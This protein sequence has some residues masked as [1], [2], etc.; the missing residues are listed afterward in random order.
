MNCILIS[1]LIKSTDLSNFVTTAASLPVAELPAHLRSFPI[2]WPFPRGDLYHWIPLLDRFDAILERFNLVYGLNSGPQTR[3]FSRVLL[4]QGIGASDHTSETRLDKIEE[5][6]FGQE[7]DREL[8]ETILAFSTLLVENCGNRS[9][10]NSSDRLGDLLNTTSLS[11]LSKSLRLAVRLAQRYHTSRQR[12]GNASQH[13]NNALLASHYNIDIEHVQKLANS[14]VKSPPPSSSL[15]ASTPSTASV[16]KGR[17]KGSLENAGRRKSPGPIHAS[18]LYAMVKDEESFSS[19]P[20][21]KGGKG[22]KQGLTDWRDWGS[23][24]YNYYQ[25]SSEEEKRPTISGIDVVPSAPSTPTP[26]RRTSGLLRPSRLSSS[27]ESSNVPNTNAITKQEEPNME[28]GMR[29]VEIPY[30]RIAS[31]ALEE[32]LKSVIPEIPK[33]SRYGLLCR[34]RIA[35]AMTHSLSTRRQILAIRILAITNLAYIYPETTF[36]LKILQQDSDEPRRLQL[37]YQL[38]DLIHPPG[39]GQAGIPIELKTIALGALEALTKH[40]SRASDVCAALNVNVNHGVLL[41]VLRKT[42]ADLAIE[43]LDGES[44]EADEWREALFSLLEALPLSGQRTAESLVAAGLFDTIIEM[45]T[46]HTNKAERSHPKVLIFLN[47]IIYTIRDAFQTFANCKGLDTISDLAAW[48]VSSSLERAEAGNGLSEHYRNQVMDYQIPYFQQQTLRWIFKFVNHMMSHGNTNFDRLLR[49]LVDSPQLL[50]GLRIVIANGPVF[51][52][53]VWSG[54]VNI[55]S[56]FIHNEPTSYAVI[57]EAGLSKGF[58]EAITLTTIPDIVSKSS[59]SEADPSLATDGIVGTSTVVIRESSDNQVSTKRAVSLSRSDDK[60]LAQGILPATDAIVTI[61]HAFGA[62][63]LNTAGLD[64]F[65]KSGALES[66]FEV[67]ESS[68]HVKSLT[69]EIDL[70]RMLGNSFDELVRH[71][72]RLKSAVMEAVIRMLARVS[73]L[74]RTKAS[75]KGVGAQLLAEDEDGDLPR[76]GSSMAQVDTSNENDGDVVMS[77]TATGSGNPD[78]E[79]ARDTSHKEFVQKLDERNEPVVSTY[80]NVAVRFLAGFFENTGLCASFIEAGGVGYILDIATLPSLPYDFNSDLTSQEIARVIHM[81]IEQ[82]PHLVLPSLLKRT[83]D[84]VDELTPFMEHDKPTAF[85]SRFALHGQAGG[86]GSSDKTD[87]ESV[88]EGTAIIKTLVRVHTLCNVLFETFSSSAFMNR[89]NHTVFTQLNLTDLY[90]PLVKSLGHLHRTCIWEEIMLQKGISEPAKDSATTTRMTKEE[91]DEAI[92]HIIN[93]A[94]PGSD[95]STMNEGN[96]TLSARALGSSHQPTK[97]ING[98]SMR[99]KHTSQFK[100]LQSL[101]YLLSQI[102]SSITPFFQ[103]LG[104]ALVTKRRAEPYPRQNAYLVADAIS[105]AS[106]DQLVYRIPRYFDSTRDRYAYWIVV[107]TS[108]SQL[109]IEGTYVNVIVKPQLTNYCRFFRAATFAVP[110]TDSTIFRSTWGTRCYQR[111]SRNFP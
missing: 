30:S 111:Y 62:I 64:L 88:D 93:G 95:V 54:A 103:G 51:G 50:N 63:C 60:P 74:C 23:V 4:E 82:K 8:I 79:S 38:A 106:L 20:K 21:S 17:E 28:G 75:A 100:N 107:L 66:F 16:S 13:L 10:Y 108:I 97:A 37:P 94:E 45:L 91:L 19:N 67:F 72:P 47:T 15:A 69:A 29:T 57:A 1:V 78:L 2:R 102:P 46:I 33:Q 109:M 92:A 35:Y 52:S 41:Y 3:S 22:H 101:R 87:L 76:N 110:N 31:T 86:K 89:P 98:S 5:L 14:F 55:L 65:M 96:R 90:V 42:A 77:D 11:L 49:N 56:S 6:G 71:H 32:I 27:E 24:S 59:D 44:T 99:D 48:E 58:L 84:A 25:T 7:G 73:D 68:D 105:R 9:L 26:V 83:Q 80:I 18:D 70:S 34:L 40:K 61:P 53:N 12:G 81:L 85:F 43:D 39:N 36:Q 104:K